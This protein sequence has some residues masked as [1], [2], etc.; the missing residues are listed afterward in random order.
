MTPFEITHRFADIAPGDLLAAMTT[1]EHQA[2]QD[3]IANIERR[4]VIERSSDGKLY[5][6]E[7]MVYPAR[8]IP[9]YV[10]PLLGGGLEC[11]EIVLW[12]KAN[13]YFEIDVHPAVLGGRS[14]VR[15]KCEAAADGS[16]TVRQYS[17][18]VTVEV[19]LIGAKVERSIVSEMLKTMEASAEATRTWL[20]QRVG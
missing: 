16:D 10:R 12:D 19:R 17:G 8:K 1:P 13:D 2:L 7:S 11:H 20:A 18:Q 9:A 4:D 3:R 14:H 6:C 15:M 5:R